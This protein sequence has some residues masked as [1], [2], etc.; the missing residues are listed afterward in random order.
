MDIKEFF[1]KL[2]KVEKK[3]EIEELFKELNIERKF[4]KN[5]DEYPSLE[6]NITKDEIEILKG[7]GFITNDNNLNVSLSKK[8]DLS[9]LEKLLFA[10][11]WKNGDLPKIKHIISGIYG[12]ESAGKVFNQ[13]GRH[14]CNKNELIIDQHVLRAYIYYKENNIIEK[15]DKIFDEYSNEYKKWI[16]NNEIFKENKDL[17]DDILF[18][19]G[20]KIKTRKKS[21]RK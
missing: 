8:H 16:N 13:F 19:I 3:K 6:F 17:M 10:V 14:L 7:E 15:V 2:D 18:A 12:E 11:I 20:R 21:I 9:T 1:I 4:Q 5:K